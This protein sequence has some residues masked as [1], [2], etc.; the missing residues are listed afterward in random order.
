MAQRHRLTVDGRVD[1]VAQIAD[2]LVALHSSDP[3]TVYLSAWARMA[4]PSIA[5]VE[6]ALYDD[7]SVVRHHAMRRTIWVM[8]PEVAR[9]AHGAATAKIAAAERRRT[10]AALTDTTDIA[11]PEAW[12]TDAFGQITELLLDHGPMTT[13]AIGNALPDLVVPVT[14]GA[15]TKNPGSMS[16]HTKVLQGAGF[17]ATLVRARPIGTWVSAEYHWSPTEH[18]LGQDIAGLV[19]DEAA[20][21]LLERWLQRFGP[22]TQTDIQWWFGWTKTL[23]RS[24]LEA[25]AA[26]EVSLGEGMVGYLAASDSEL[27]PDPGPWVR[28]LPGLDPSAMGWKERDWYV[29][30]ALVPRVFD[31]FG[32]AGP[33]VWV[34][35]EIVGGW[36]Q[37]SDG[38]VV[39]E[40]ARKLDRTHQQL[41]EDAVVDM[42]DTVGDVV[43]RPRFPAPVQKDLFR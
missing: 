31:Q 29:D 34:D 17:D 35:G 23:T 12:L 38:Q 28:L 5:A 42:Q 8:T 32:N 10:I 6:S 22:A 20:P 9:L 36:I 30:T 18:W 1:D 16:A 27:A 11:D 26:V 37:R 40:L 14:F 33:T 3:C 19:V 4:N 39:V 41:L 15:R 43:V 2:D 21:A 24:S 13:R 7:R 25:V